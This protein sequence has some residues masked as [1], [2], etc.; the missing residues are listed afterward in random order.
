[1]R[2]VLFCL[3]DLGLV[4]E[5]PSSTMSSLAWLV[6]AVSNSRKT[7][8]GMVVLVVGWPVLRKRRRLFPP[9]PSSS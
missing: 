8:K 4:E 9:S 7:D 1:V 5:V 6:S 3:R 2:S